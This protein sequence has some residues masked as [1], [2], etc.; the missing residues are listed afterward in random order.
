MSSTSLVSGQTLFD[1][2]IRPRQHLRR[3]RKADL[4][5]RLRFM[6]NSNLVACCT[7]KS[8]GLANFSSRSK[9]NGKVIETSRLSSS[10]KE[11][12]RRSVFDRRAR[13]YVCVGEKGGLSGYRCIPPDL[14]VWS[15]V[16]R[17]TNQV[18]AQFAFLVEMEA[19]CFDCRTNSGPKFGIKIIFVSQP[20]RQKL[21]HH[22]FARSSSDWNCQSDLFCRLQVYDEFKLRCLLYR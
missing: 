18:G 10:H 1:H 12:I 2:L 20:P 17:L 11:F 22:L 13:R 16:D 9:R 5:C 21:F 19:M 8:A 4:F 3:N 7:G 14:S 15:S 6:T